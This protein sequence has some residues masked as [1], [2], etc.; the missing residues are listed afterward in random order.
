MVL[1]L[2]FCVFGKVAKVLKLLLVCF[3]VFWGFC[4]VVSSW[5]FAGWFILVYLGLEGLGVFV[6]LVCFSFVQVLFLFVF[7]CFGFVFVLLLDF[8]W[9]CSCYFCVLCFFLVFFWGGGLFL[10]SFWEGLRVRWGGPK[11]H[12]IGPKPSLFFVLFFC[13]L[14]FCFLFVFGRFRGTVRWPKGPPHLAL[15]PPFFVFVFGFPF[16]AFNRKTSFPPP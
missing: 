7:V 16:F 12:L 13:L 2:V 10:V 14:F 11:G 5:V 8:C 9:C 3:P 4:G 6:V 15:N 1:C